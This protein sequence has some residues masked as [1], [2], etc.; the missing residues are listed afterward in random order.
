MVS[1]RVKSF[2][3]FG[4][5]KRV[6]WHDVNYLRPDIDVLGHTQGDKDFSKILTEKLGRNLAVTEAI[7]AIG[8]DLCVVNDPDCGCWI[9]ATDDRLMSQWTRGMWDSCEAVAEALLAMPLPSSE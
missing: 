7:K 8:T 4:L 9:L 5:T 6:R 2:P 3:V 1:D